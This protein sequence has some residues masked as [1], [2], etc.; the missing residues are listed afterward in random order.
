MRFFG[1]FLLI[2][3][4][5]RV[6]AFAQLLP[7][8]QPE[9]DA[10]HALQLC[11]NS[12][13][14]P[15]SYQGNGL[16]PDLPNTPCGTVG[17]PCGE[18]NVVWLKLVV[19][20]AGTIVFAI[21]PVDAQ[22]DYDFAVLNITNTTCAN[23]AMSNVVRCNFNNNLPVS[24]NGIL[25]LNTTST[26]TSVQ[27]GTTGSPYLQQ[28]TAAAGDVYLIMINNFGSGGAPSSGFTI[29][30]TG[31]TATFVDNSPP[32]FAS[33]SSATT[34]TYKNTVT[35]HMNTPIA[36]NSITA[37]GSDFNLTPGGT[38]SSASGVN[39][40]GLNGYTQDVI[41]TF[42]PSLPPAAYT[43]HAHTG[44]D[45]N[46]LLNL[47]GTAIPLTES[48]TF[49]VTANASFASASLACTTLTVTTNVP[50]LCSSI[51]ANG[52]DFNLT[53]P[54]P[55]AV[56]N[57]IGVNCDAAGYSSTIALTLA[58][59]VATSGTY[60]VTAQNGT[61]GNTLLD[62][63]GTNLP[64]G[65]TTTFS[66]VSKPTLTLPANLTTCINTGIVLPLQITNPSNTGTYTY[67]WA[68]AAGLNNT[69]IAQPT[70][71]P[72]GDVT[73]TV[74]V[75]NTN[76]SMCT[77]TASVLV[78]NLQGF[79]ILNHDTAIC[80]GASVQIAVNGSDDYTYTW[81]PTTGVSNPNIKNPVITPAT[82]TTYTLT[83]THAGCNDS[84]Q[85]ITIDVQP[86]PEGITLIPEATSVC[87]YDTISLHAIAYPLSFNFNYTWTPAADMAF[88][89]GPNNAYIGNTSGYVKVSASTPIGCSAADSVFINV[90]PGNFLT[91]NTNDTG[92]CVSGTIPLLA[93]N[94]VSYTWT[95]PYGLSATD[96]PDPVASPH[97]STNYMVIG[98][99][100]HGCRD[101]QMVTIGVFPAGVINMPD[102]VDIYH[103]ESY[104][105][106]SSTNCSAFHWFPPAGIN[107]VDIGNPTFNP[108]VRTRYFV[109]GTTG[110]GCVVTDSID[111]LVKETIIDMPNAFAP[112][113]GANTIFKPS[114]RGIVQLKSFNIYNRWGQK[115]FESTNID[116]GWDGT[117]KNTPQP[118]GVYIY[119]IDAITDSGNA[120]TQRGNVTLV[121]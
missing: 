22:D 80:A 68:P 48:L 6:P 79:D 82:H 86:N 81:T 99:D 60:T 59:P 57:A 34:C 74:T 104:T 61:D 119:T 107:S 30:F 8:N 35:V 44:T 67:Q 96:I 21:T 110:P 23:L 84:S 5:L 73:Y 45:N 55:I 20:T 77:S 29:S 88:T 24:N 17:A 85:L 93:S 111:I 58:N 37:T 39:C 120:F 50:I 3:L 33:L 27:G 87:Q 112:G 100:I 32:H 49:N 105:L 75:G 12:F 7:I 63:C 114:K 28:I 38:I 89:G 46:T 36:C 117:F 92:Y 41:L 53:G 66:A 97:T 69:T 4:C 19:N 106:V 13:S 108:I 26:L 40:T 54:G 64:V 16:V 15:Y 101:T 42:A 76:T 90:F 11:G 62:D 51:A 71:N 103:G 43:L 109:T 25:G 118:V 116:K 70:A 83:A 47:C 52:S 65:N 94:A 56:T 102:S 72:T 121:R 14:T 18:N 1:L 91:V 113:S 2:L 78:H 115:V 31:S 9:Q 98:K 10:C 95:P